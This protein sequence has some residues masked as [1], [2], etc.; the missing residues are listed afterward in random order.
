MMP[1]ALLVPVR[2]AV[3]AFFLLTCAYAVLNCSPF[4][5]DMF[6]KPQLIPWLTRFVAWHHVWFAVA[7]V[8]SVAALAPA[9]ASRARHGSARAAHWLALGYV[10][11]MG[12]TAAALLV[13]PFLPTLWNDG[14]A[15][16]TAL[17]SLVPLVW[18]AVIDHLASHEA[19]LAG[20][21]ESALTTGHRRLLVA[22]GGTAL[23]VW[24]VH[25]IRA[26]VHGAEQGSGLAWTLTAIWTLVLAAA[27]F[28]FVFA[29]LA[30][31]DRD[32]RANGSAEA[33]RV[34]PDR[35]V[36]GGRPVRAVQACG[37]ADLV[38]RS[39]RFGDSRRGRGRDARAHLV[40]ID[41][42]AARTR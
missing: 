30:V 13:S 33:A 29:M 31:V 39:W 3:S 15:L 23:Y 32:C 17:A 42:A 36:D 18:L 4:A 19:I 12:L 28:S 11:S 20:E 8:A 1:F 27:V 5:F 9:L 41:A 34:Q 22:C 16:P 10:V 38:P 24:V 40:G 25:V 35:G 7:Y 6:I 26:F 14:R 2:L 37:L 21:S